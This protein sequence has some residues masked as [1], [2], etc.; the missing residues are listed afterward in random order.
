MNYMGLIHFGSIFDTICLWMFL[1]IGTF[2]S[3]YKSPVHGGSPV[4]E[5]E[6]TELVSFSAESS[7]ELI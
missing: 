7:A 2:M 5:L 4:T 3:Y 6:V 1:W